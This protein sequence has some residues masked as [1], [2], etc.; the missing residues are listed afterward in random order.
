MPTNSPLK[1]P[2]IEQTSHDLREGIESSR[3]FVRKS[4]VLIELS[5]CQPPAA[6]NVNEGESAN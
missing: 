5:E 2:D 4:R 6:A 3:E 1:S